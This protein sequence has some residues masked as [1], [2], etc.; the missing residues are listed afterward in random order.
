MESLSRLAPVFREG[1]SVTAGNA[2]T[3]SDGAH[4]PVPQP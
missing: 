4:T 2:S 3:L 1:G